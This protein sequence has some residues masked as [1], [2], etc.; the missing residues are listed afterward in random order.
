MNL[1]QMLKALAEKVKGLDALKTAAFADDATEDQTKALDDELEAIKALKAKIA[2]AEQIEAL[3]KEAAE[4]ASAPADVDVAKAAAQPTEKM[5][6]L[7]KVGV[8]ITAL[9]KSNAAGTGKHWDAVADTMDKMGYGSIAEEFDARNKALNTGTDA[10]GGFTVAEDFNEEIFDE[11]RPYSAFLR[12]M[13]DV[14]PMPNGNYRQS[15]IASRPTV[16]YRAEGAVIAASE[17][18]FR[19]I[20][21]SAKLLGGIVPMTNQLIN[22]TG[23]RASAAAQRTLAVAM[24]LT[25]DSA[26]FEGTGLSNTPLGLFNQSGITTAVATDAT[27]PT[28]AQVDSD[29]RKLINVM[30]TFAG[31]QLG[32]AWVMPQRVIGYLQDMRDGNGNPYYPSMQGDNPSF[33]GYPVLKAGTVTIAGGVGTNET[34]I[35][36][37]SFGN[38]IFGETG[39]LTIKLSD[40]ASYDSG[41]GTMV[42]AFANDLTL[43]RTTM[44]H[45]WQPRYNEAIGTLTACK[46]GA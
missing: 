33:K 4:P 20:D 38:I 10:N 39:G 24:G 3:E 44:E 21:M 43:I 12:G 22:W 1:E 5:G 40:E 11:L 36:L 6:A 14:V 30:E 18:T 7:Q 13:P 19:E 29:T 35:S 25:M 15:A 23:Q 28:V 45:D 26:G 31:L 34:T 46:W 17:P 16:G 2:K 42:S 32:L 9:M 37:V 8:S 27:D 41:G